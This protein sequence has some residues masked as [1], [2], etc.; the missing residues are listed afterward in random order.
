MT[1][2]DTFDL[3]LSRLSTSY[4]DA[5]S[6]DIS[7]LKS[8]IAAASTASIIVVGSG[9]SFTVASLL[10]GLH[11][12]YAGR[13][14]R[15]ATPL[16]LICNP[17]L[18]SASPVFLISAE[19]KN[20]DILECLQRAR[21][22]SSR[23]INVLTNRADSPLADAAKEMPNVK[24]HVFDISTRD[25]YLAT[26][27]LMFDSV[28]I[29]RAY[30]EFDEVAEHLPCAFDELIS[31][32]GQTDVEYA[33]FA[34]VVA[35]RGA[36]LVLYSPQLRAAATDLES[37]L[38]ESALAH[39]QLADLRSFAHGRHLWLADRPRA[40]AIVVLVEPTLEPLW[41]ET[42]RLLPKDTPILAIRLPGSRPRDLI[43]ALY[44]QME[45][46]ALI[47]RA[48]HK[49]AANPNV[50]DFGKK[51]HYINLPILVP[52]PITADAHPE[53][54]KSEILGL[55]WATRIRSG[56][57]VRERESY[58]A[59]LQSQIFKAVVFDYDGTLC[60]S[61][62]VE[63]PPET[64]ITDRIEPLLKAGIRIGIASGRGDSIQKILASCFPSDS[65][66]IV[67]GLYNGGWIGD[68]SQEPDLSDEPNEFISHAARIAHR[69]QRLGVPIAKVRVTQP[70]QVSLR[71][72]A[73][74]DAESIWFVVAD[75]LRAEGLDLLKVVRSKH[76][77]DILSATTNKSR[78]VQ[79]M[80][81]TH[82]IDPYEIL[83]F[84]D[85]G[86]WPGN[87]AALLEHRFSLSVDNPS[88][89]LDRGWN[90]APTSKREV[91]A[92]VWYL[93]HFKIVGDGAFQVL[94]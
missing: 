7:R 23:P 66:R 6:R 77:V 78:V 41:N 16:E 29:A 63:R 55:N 1:N 48:M 64:R 74:V 34:D 59:K 93:D 65:H 81:Q 50:P 82:E 26:N 35:E 17:S 61:M 42:R 47:A 89:L 53:R 20:P 9:G 68:A 27:S 24:A 36:V 80:I 4:T 72:E 70:Y 10:S 5:L 30:Q 13:V 90:L 38:A 60:S 28:L 49:D 33:A 45:L 84:G 86:A 15:P 54:S 67:L 79:H 14:S 69:L 25:G 52:P 11:E 40:L 39:C 8:A 51:I 73:G 58:L 62:N 71:L 22:H 88:R 57:L 2:R 21:N 32:D 92:M 44:R 83:T 3:E 91:D 85:H 46:V 12:A 43:A 18:A 31:S 94:L 56:A 19:G 87:D 76:S 37:K 75:A